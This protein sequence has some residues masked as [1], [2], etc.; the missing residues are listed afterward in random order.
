MLPSTC[1]LIST[2][3]PQ[4]KRSPSTTSLETMASSKRNTSLPTEPLLTVGNRLERSSGTQPATK[5]AAQANTNSRFISA[6][7]LGRPRGDPWVE[8]RLGGYT[9]EVVPRQPPVLF[10]RGRRVSFRTPARI[11]LSESWRSRTFVGPSPASPPDP[12]SAGSG[13]NSVRPW[14]RGG[15]GSG[16]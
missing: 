13:Q 9:S 10:D 7:S 1:P 6:S 5:A 16:V 4:A 8:L 14:R 3:V 12:L 15:G 11:I 2:V